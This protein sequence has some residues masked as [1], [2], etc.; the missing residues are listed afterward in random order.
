VTGTPT[1]PGAMPE[2]YAYTPITF[3]PSPA[4]CPPVQDFDARI[5]GESSAIPLAY[6]VAGASCTGADPSILDVTNSAS[7]E[8]RDAVLNSQIDLGITSAP[9]TPDEL[10][11]HPEV[12]RVKYA[13]I[14]LTAVVVAFR[15]ADPVTNTPIT[16]LVLTPRLVARLISDSRPEELFGDAEFQSLNPGRRWPPGGLAHPLLRAEAN[17]DTG[18]V[19]SWITRNPSA[20]AF[21]DGADSLGETVTPAWKNVAYPT[22]IFESRAATSGYIPLTGQRTVGQRLFYGVT[23]SNLATGVDYTGVMGVVDLPTARLYGLSVAKLVNP[24]GVAV[25]PTDEAILSGYRAMTSNADGTKVAD[26]ATTDPAAYP[27]VKIDY[28]M[29]T[30]TLGTGRVTKTARFITDATG[31][32]QDTGGLLGYVPLPAA[33]RAQAATVAAGLTALITGIDPSS[34]PSTDGSIGGSGYDST[35]SYS[36]D[37]GYD[38]TGAVD[39]GPGGSGAAAP[40][41]HKGLVRFQPVVALSDPRRT[42]GLIVVLLLGVVAGLA[43]IAPSAWAGARRLVRR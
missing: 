43:A 11:A 5:G 41:V 33:E 16:D 28:G 29:V 39:G 34:N 37:S 23:P 4:D 40:L 27:L 35:G 7:N 6:R 13:P 18:L 36:Y 25:A 19:T 42:S 24:A 15:L 38:S 14:D 17:A 21:L 32:V 8:G 26:F 3:A 10:A 31:T 1:A 20:R 30:N 9:A 22:D 12:L 2:L